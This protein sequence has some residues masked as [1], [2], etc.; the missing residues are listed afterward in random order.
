MLT[1]TDIP[2]LPAGYTA[3]RPTHDD[4]PAILAVIAAC[5]I[6]EAG[7]ADEFT[8]EDIENDWKRTDPN[9]NAYVVCAPDGSLIASATVYPEGEARVNLDV[10]ILPEHRGHGLGTSLTHALELRAREILADAPADARLT[11]HTGVNTSNRHAT[12]LLENEGY[13]VVR[14]FWQMRIEM[15]APPPAPVWPE[16]VTVRACVR[17][18]DER[19][20]FDT[21]E[22]AFEDHWGHVTHEYD[23]WYA[24][25]VAS[26]SYD[27]AL[28][29]LAIAGDEPAGAVRGRLRGD[30]GWIN[31][32]GVR[33]LWRRSG[34]GMAL[35]LQ[36]FAAF[37]AVGARAVALGVD[38][39]NPTGATRLYERAGMR[40]SRQF[41]VYEKELR[42]GV[43]SDDLRR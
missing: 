20:I 13:T 22:E 37:Y 23:E 33:R 35:L 5:D 3:R 36:A 26:E 42:P 31:T 39:R 11:T 29:F 16:G 34:L 7:S 30:E 12:E 14:H 19:P 10:Y 41:T 4:I 25:N 8:A 1:T 2:N 40:V 32:L 24:M 18:Q 43:E 27:P 6:E 9:E 38:A 28:W 15:E 17:G 21:I